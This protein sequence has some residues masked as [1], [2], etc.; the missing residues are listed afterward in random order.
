MVKGGIIMLTPPLN[1]NLDN[2]GPWSQDHRSP[3]CNLKDS[4]KMLLNT[5]KEIGGNLMGNKIAS[6]CGSMVHQWTSQCTSEL[7]NLFVSIGW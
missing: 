7:M 1:P 2:C 4:K 3:K 6:L 5:T